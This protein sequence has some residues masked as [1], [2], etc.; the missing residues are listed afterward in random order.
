MSNAY[1]TSP[2]EHRDAVLGIS[3]PLA[4]IDYYPAVCGKPSPALQKLRPILKRL[5][6]SLKVDRLSAG[7]SRAIKAA[8]DGARDNG[9]GYDTEASREEQMR[10]WRIMWFVSEYAFGDAYVLAE[11]WRNKALPLWNEVKGII[12]RV[13]RAMYQH[14]PEDEE[15]A[16]RIWCCHASPYKNP[17]LE[18]IWTE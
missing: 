2:F 9:S 16:C 18:V 6:D 15:E 10:G 5:H 8:C 12:D 7:E 3:F 13:T 17:R 11:T 1:P 4:A 14:H